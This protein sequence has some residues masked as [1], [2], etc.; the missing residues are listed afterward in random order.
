MTKIN[1]N[2]LLI[3]GLVAFASNAYAVEDRSDTSD[4]E[5]KEP[6]CWDFDKNR[7]EAECTGHEYDKFGI[8][9]SDK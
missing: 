9:D 2:K 5:D 1:F 7:P 8:P 3:I 6:S 4:N